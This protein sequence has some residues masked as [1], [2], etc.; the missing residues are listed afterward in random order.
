[1]W[2]WSGRRGALLT[3]PHLKRRREAPEQRITYSTILNYWQIFNSIDQIKRKAVMLSLYANVAICYHLLALY[4]ILKTSLIGA[5]ERPPRPL[6]L[7]EKWTEEHKTPVP[8]QKS[9]R[10]INAEITNVLAQHWGKVNPGGH[11][12]GFSV[13]L[14]YFYIF[15]CKWLRCL[16]APLSENIFVKLFLM[17]IL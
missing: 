15:N 12:W 3:F 10:R 16:K 1:L 13:K 2:F 5:S 11:H 9:L 6:E 14:S 4:L 7:L 17:L 8:S